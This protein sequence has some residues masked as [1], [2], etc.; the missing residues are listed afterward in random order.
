MSRQYCE[1]C[2]YPISVCFCDQI[3][4]IRS[5]IH[6]DI[7]QHPSESKVFKN[8]ARLLA[9]CYENTSIWKGEKPEEF[10]ELRK[11]IE[12]NVTVHNYLLYPSKHATSIARLTPQDINATSKVRILIIDGTWKK[13]FK[14]IQLN[15]WLNDLPHIKITDIRS[16][17]TIRKSNK[18]SHALSTLEAAKA[19]LN[20]LAP[21]IDTRS[22]QNC[23]NKL[24]SLYLQR[25]GKNYN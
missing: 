15:P 21:E 3:T 6:F 2:H 17:Y 25:A 20:N 19:C 13:S 8:T 12:D 5:P 9:L 22:L 16:N 7:L 14:I 4:K 1:T 11:H 18:D 23:F 24:Q 10:G